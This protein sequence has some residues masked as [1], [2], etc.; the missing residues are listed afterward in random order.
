[1]LRWAVPI[2]TSFGLAYALRFGLIEPA[3]LAHVC[4]AA[5]APWWCGLRGAVIVAFA[6]GGLALA[7]LASA[8]AATLLRARGWALA[9][10]CLGV[11]GLV[12]F[13]YEAG[14]VALLAGLLVLA[15]DEHARRQQT[16]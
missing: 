16:G 1:M 9:A 14:A 7:A 4:G 8:G 13:S 15:R 10:V 6:S 3:A 11:A 12:L 2:G 5:A